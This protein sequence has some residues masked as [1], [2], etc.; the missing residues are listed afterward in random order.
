MYILAIDTTGPIGTV[1]LGEINSFGTGTK[2]LHDGDNSFVPVPKLL[3]ELPMKV[4]TMTMSH[5]KNLVPMIDELFKE[6]GVTGSDIA[7]VAASCGPG[8]FTGIRIGVSTARA[9]AQAWNVPCISVPTLEVFREKCEEDP[10]CVI[11]NARRGQVYG[12]CF[13]KGGRALIEPGP[14]M[15][16]DM[17]S[18][19][20]TLRLAPVFYGD[21]ID[22]YFDTDEFRDRVRSYKTAPPESRYQTA[23]MAARYAMEKWQEGDTV[24]YGELLP[25]YMRE[26]EAEQRLRDGSLERMRKEKMDRFMKMVGKK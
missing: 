1:S 16:S 19:I 8:S 3:S 21:G 13:D 15:L 7:A 25:D 18:R 26:S 14:Y 23:D 10:V 5:L 17:L 12:A 6:E 22:A 20:E 11:F 24:E 2:L 9:L 4:T